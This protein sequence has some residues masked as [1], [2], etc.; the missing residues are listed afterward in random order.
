MGAVEASDRVLRWFGIKARNEKKDASILL[1]S[2]ISNGYFLSYYNKL[3]S[4][5]SDSTLELSF[6]GRIRNI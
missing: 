5:F 2:I 1:T 3:S 4:K 6:S